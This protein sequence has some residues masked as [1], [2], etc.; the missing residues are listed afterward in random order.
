[1]DLSKLKKISHVEWEIPK[2]GDM[3]VPG[4]LFALKKL[5]EE[6][7]EKV[8]EQVSNVATLPGIQ[9]ASLAMPD[10]HWGYGFP[11]GGVAAFDGDNKGVVSVGGVGFDIN[12][13]VRTLKTNLTLD[14]IKPKLKEF[15]DTL[16]DT[17]PAGLGSRGEIELKGKQ[18]NEVLVDGAQWIVKNGYGT[19][20]DLKYI[21]ENGKVEGA[22]P[23]NVSELAIRREK[24]Q[25]GTL[26]SGNHY[27][28]I[29]IV[30]DIFDEK[31]AERFGLFENQVLLTLHCGSR[32]LGH[33]IGSDYLKILAQ[34][35][36]KY[37][38]PIREKE[39]VC[40]PINSPEGQKYIGA[41]NCGINYAFANR[42]VIA[43]LARETTK[44][45]FP[46]AEVNMLY[47]VGHN[48]C[49]KEKHKI[50]NKNKEVWVH[51]KGATRAFGPDR[52]ELPQIYQGVGQ[53][54]LIGGTMG[55]YSYILVGTPESRKGFESVC[56]G[57]G[58]AM[59]RTQAKKQFWGE[60]IL[61]ELGLK[62]IYVRAHSMAG[63]AEEAPG[64]YKDVNEVI[65]S[66]HQTHLARRVVR[67]VPVGNIKG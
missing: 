13:G 35:S 25:V 39:L 59:S 62:G 43:H 8:F 56:H 42:Q 54:V 24:K 30:K 23:E 29:Q 46:D 7:D 1:M 31:T 51:R 47:D 17:V 63:A 6:M 60:T 9:K 11:I 27:L 44:K 61:K 21:E 22:L 67:V 45:I 52:K 66:I 41:M 53:P 2:T 10:A 48:T 18:I 57:A 32:A 55:T 49:K 28:E 19:E 5:V 38:I 26:G 15:V 34:A 20:D 58:R 36:R 16:F 4:K 14:Q 12:C 40:A 50:D 64:A 33:Q 37:N 65:E 3:L